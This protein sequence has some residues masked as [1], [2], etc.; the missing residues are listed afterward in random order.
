T[1]CGL[2]PR[3]RAASLTVIGILDDESRESSFIGNVTGVE[4]A[5]AR[6]GDVDGAFPSLS[7]GSI[8]EGESAVMAEVTPR[9]CRIREITVG[10]SLARAVRKKSSAGSEWK[11]LDAQPDLEC[12]RV[13]GRRFRGWVRGIP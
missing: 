12:N 5:V 10:C 13:D 11:Q 6:S 2:T 3:N 4:R 1:V 8:Q 7:D 9:P